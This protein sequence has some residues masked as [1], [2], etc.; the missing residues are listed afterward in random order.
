L[1]NGSHL[2]CHPG[3]KDFAALLFTQSTSWEIALRNEC[4]DV[5]NEVVAVENGVDDDWHYGGQ[6]VLAIHLHQHNRQTARLE[7]S[8][9]L[10]A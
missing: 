1:S 5:D 3:G 4:D 6:E 7:N 2:S 8:A 10:L 9:V